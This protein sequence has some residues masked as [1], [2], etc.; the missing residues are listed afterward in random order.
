MRVPVF[1]LAGPAPILSHLARQEEHLQYLIRCVSLPLSLSRDLVS[2]PSLDTR[3]HVDLLFTTPLSL[4]RLLSPSFPDPLS[5]PILS[6][7]TF[8]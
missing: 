6:W 7:A 8:S 4:A 1:D 3:V 5:S 2:T